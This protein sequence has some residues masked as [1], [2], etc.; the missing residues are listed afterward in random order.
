V[1]NG[2]GTGS[3]SIYGGRFDDENFTLRHTGPGILSMANSGTFHL[4]LTHIEQLNFL[5]HL[6]KVILVIHELKIFLPFRTQY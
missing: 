5:N 3:T 4:D 1:V 6:M 2:D